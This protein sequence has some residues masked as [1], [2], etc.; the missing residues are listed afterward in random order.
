M[1]KKTIGNLKN[2]LSDETKQVV[3]ESIKSKTKEKSSKTGSRVPVRKSQDKNKPGKPK[4]VEK[5][6]SRAS[7]MNHS[8]EKA[9]TEKFTP[10]IAQTIAVDNLERPIS[11]EENINQKIELQAAGLDSKIEQI[12]AQIEIQEE[13]QKN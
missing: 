7:N 6:E 13:P 9:K 2:V 4:L 5:K 11:P 10:K 1:K 8:R 3:E 12:P